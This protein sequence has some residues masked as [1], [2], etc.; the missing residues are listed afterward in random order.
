MIKGVLFDF[1]GTMF[2]DG[3]KHR[4]A[5]NAFSMKYRN[6][7]ISDEEMK[8]MHGKNNTAIIT[9]LLGD[10]CNMSEDDKILLSK[11][12]EKMYREICLKDKENLYL[13]EG[14]EEFLD[15]LKRNQIPVTI[16]SA[17]IK[18]NIDFYF[19]VFRLE[20]WFDKDKVVYDDG[21]HNNKVSM[22]LDGAKKIGVTI[23]ECLVFEDSYS[24]IKYAKE[25]GAGIIVAITS[26]N[27]FIEY[28][29]NL[30]ISNV[31]SN[32]KEFDR[33]ILKK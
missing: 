31:I 7:P 18:E 33:N 28:K 19:S 23:N 4:E 17:S 32:F 21:L 22:F 24:G 2:F 14:L 9:D 30:N 12:K 3:D 6:K 29:S 8:Y 20:N 11:K 5:W 1:N 25:C 16:C 13:V 26:P 27:R 10:N 15:E